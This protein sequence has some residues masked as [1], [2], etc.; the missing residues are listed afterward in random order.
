MLIKAFRFLRNSEGATAVEYS[1]IAALISVAAIIAL[2]DVGKSL[3][4][5]FGTTATHVSSTTP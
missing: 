2:T 1:L 3:N 4:Q 5:L